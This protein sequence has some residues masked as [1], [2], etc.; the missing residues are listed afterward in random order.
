LL[1]KYQRLKYNNIY[2]MYKTHTLRVIFLLT[3]IISFSFF[4]APN[5][6]A[7]DFSLK[8]DETKCTPS[9]VA[10]FFDQPVQWYPSKTV[11]NSVTIENKSESTQYIGHR[12]VNMQSSQGA[13]LA[14]ALEL[15]IVRKSVNK[16]VW[17]SSLTEFYTTSESV[18]GVLGPNKADSFEYTI[19]M[20]DVGNEYQGK[21]TQFG[22]V[23]GFFMPTVTPTQPLH[24]F[25]HKYLPPY[26]LSH[27]F[28]HQ[29]PHPHPQHNHLKV[30]FSVL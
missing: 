22:L 5:V 1:K 28:R 18:L 8:C 26:L 21:S 12:A 24:Q 9:S 23:F 20:R 15:R 2:R 13:D 25:T 10:K 29:H 4:T 6:F 17:K 27:Q 7:L 11:S 19:T 14:N 16:E 30:G 3:V